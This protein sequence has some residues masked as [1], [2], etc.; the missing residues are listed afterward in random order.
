VPRIAANLNKEN[1][2]LLITLAQGVQG[3]SDQRA[4]L[5]ELS[6]ALNGARE[7]NSIFPG[8][9]WAITLNWELG[10][11][12]S[13][14]Y[15]ILGMISMIRNSSLGTGLRIGA[16]A[17]NCE[18]AFDPAQYPQLVGVLAGIV[19][20]SDY[21]MCNFYPDY[22][23]SMTSVEAGVTYVSQVYAKFLALGKV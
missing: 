9:V 1:G 17:Q 18:I 19:R 10:S 4:Q 2:S 13:E 23:S 3:L 14:G 16:R 5:E 7:A 11:D 12:V 8:T 15:K 20:N 6:S 22:A 21:I